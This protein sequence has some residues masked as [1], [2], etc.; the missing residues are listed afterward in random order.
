LYLKH[1]TPLSSHHTELC[2]L[3]YDTIIQI[4]LLCELQR[5]SSLLAF[6][7]LWIK[8]ML[9]II[10]PCYA[11]QGCLQ[12]GDGNRRLCRNIGNLLPTYAA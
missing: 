4:K 7:V 2:R 8:Y 12:L 3:I 5:K 11:I 6:V 10:S 9:P 1:K